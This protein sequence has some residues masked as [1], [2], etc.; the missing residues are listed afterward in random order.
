MHKALN[1]RVRTGSADRNHSPAYACL[2]ARRQSEP[3]PS[4]Y[5]PVTTTYVRGAGVR[6]A[7]RPSISRGQMG[8]YTLRTDVPGAVTTNVNKDGPAAVVH[9]PASLR[10]R[11]RQTRGGGALAPNSRIQSREAR[12]GPPA[13][14]RSWRG[15]NRARAGAGPPPLRTVTVTRNV[16]LT[17]AR[18]AAISN[19]A[20]WGGWQRG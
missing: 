1:T 5:C 7:R 6:I 2:I 13:T 16:G 9:Y 18:V 20:E 12:P 19:Y 8:A 10:I 11:M 14:Y 3:N 15:K 4:N 17:V